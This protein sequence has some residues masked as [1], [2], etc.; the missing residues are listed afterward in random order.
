MLA[1]A[2]YLD[3]KVWQIDVKTAFLN[4]ELNKEMY[5]IQPEGFIS[6][7]ESKVCKL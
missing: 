5:M 1:V 2:A 4:R 7:D 3:Y 6:S